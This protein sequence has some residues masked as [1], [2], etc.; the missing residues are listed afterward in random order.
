MQCDE[1]VTETR[2][3]YFSGERIICARFGPKWRHATS[4]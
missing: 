1:R 3:N 2:F 4:H